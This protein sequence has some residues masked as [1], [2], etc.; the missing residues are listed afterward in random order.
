[1]FC[2]HPL[3]VFDFLRICRVQLL[4]LVLLNFF[5]IFFISAKPHFLLSLSHFTLL[6]NY[7]INYRYSVTTVNKK[8]S[9]TV[10]GTRHTAARNVSK[11]TGKGSTSAS[12]GGSDNDFGYEN[13]NHNYYN[14]I[15][16]LQIFKPVS[17]PNR[18]RLFLFDLFFLI[19]II[20]FL[21]FILNNFLFLN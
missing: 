4:P 11:S 5:Y 7:I 19:F 9:T 13:K 18:D 8:R 17:I 15:D 2:R 1:M 16:D 14:L 20:F 10:A 6:F 3:R 21:D 12:A